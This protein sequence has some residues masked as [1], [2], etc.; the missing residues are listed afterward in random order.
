LTPRPS[1]SSPQNPL[2]RQVVKL[3]DNRHRQRAGVVLVDGSREITRAI[4]G[5]LRLQSLLTTCSEGNRQRHLTGD[6]DE[7][8]ERLIADAGNLAVTVTD[9][10]M[11]KIAYGGNPRGAVAVFDRPQPPRLEELRLP[12]NPL[13]LILV[14]IEKPGN[15]GAIF[16]SADAVGADAVVLCET[17]C[18]LFNPNLI[19]G[20]LGTVFTTPTAETSEPETI[21]WIR[22]LGLTC[23]NT[24]VD[25]P[26]SFWDADYRGP[27]A[28]VVG[29]EASGLGTRWGALPTESVSAES[30]HWSRGSRSV[31]VSIPMRGVADSLNVSVAAAV[32]LFEAGR[33]RRPVEG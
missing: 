12:E 14:G 9:E 10:L 3:R 28:I 30:S 18:D 29:S 24:V 6:Q 17:G 21:A 16:R 7:L 15:A 33:Q 31:A 23:V 22:D 32:L 19:R 2:I 5:G 8:L 1:I 11:S 20:S 26:R 4:Q 27:T 13:V 25:A